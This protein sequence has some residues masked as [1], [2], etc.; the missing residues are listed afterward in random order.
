MRTR[1]TILRAERRA[2]RS[3]HSPVDATLGEC[4][5]RRSPGTA[6]ARDRW[7]IARDL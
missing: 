6:T 4:G 1:S 7:L 5:W 3:G 2:G